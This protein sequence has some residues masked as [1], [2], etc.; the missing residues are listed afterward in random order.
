MADSISKPIKIYGLD[1]FS[2][3][4][5]QFIT[6][7]RTTTSY[8]LKRQRIMTALRCGNIIEAA[9]LSP[10]LSVIDT[11]DFFSA[12]EAERKAMVM[13]VLS[14]M[15]GVKS[16]KVKAAK[17]RN[18]KASD[19]AQEV[20]KELPAKKAISDTT[21]EKPQ[22]PAPMVDRTAGESVTRDDFGTTEI[23]ESVQTNKPKI[24]ALASLR[25][26]AMPRK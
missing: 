1:E 13:S 24:P 22:P 14:M 17:P 3:S 10:L 25:S 2:P 9:G 4:T 12:D 23:I 19:N 15:S 7:Y 20:T 8:N 6:E 5:R 18:Q 26:T 16:A 11:D 21:M